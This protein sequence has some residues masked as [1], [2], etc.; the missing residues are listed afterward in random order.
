MDRSEIEIGMH[1]QVVRGWPESGITGQIFVVSE[2]CAAGDD[3]GIRRD[4]HD[5]SE[6]Y[7]HPCTVEHVKPFV[8]DGYYEDGRARAE[9]PQI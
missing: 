1:V 8:A 7:V 2:I 5:E 6:W 4:D 9:T 3:I